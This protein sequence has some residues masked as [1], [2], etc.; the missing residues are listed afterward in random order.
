MMLIL[1]RIGEKIG[2]FFEL[3]GTL[4]F[5][6]SSLYPQL[7]EKSKIAFDLLCH[8]SIRQYDPTKSAWRYNL[9]VLSE[10][11]LGSVAQNSFYRQWIVLAAVETRTNQ[12]SRVPGALAGI[13]WP[14]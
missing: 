6:G 3:Q 13:Q 14:G 2:L 11:E 4:T 7:K 9:D 8:L 10:R 12:R 5:Q 1:I